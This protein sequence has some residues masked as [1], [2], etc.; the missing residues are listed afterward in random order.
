MLFLL[1]PICFLACFARDN[2]RHT[3]IFPP[4]ILPC[5]KYKVGITQGTNGFSVVL[6]GRFVVPP[7]SPKCAVVYCGLLCTVSCADPL[8]E[9][10][11][12]ISPLLTTNWLHHPRPS[13]AIGISHDRHTNK[14]LPYFLVENYGRLSRTVMIM[15]TVKIGVTKFVNDMQVGQRR[16]RG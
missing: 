7:I 16:R 15:Q 9:A 14:R 1:L 8:L 13:L 4:S 12:P 6:R 2:L 11:S 10:D 3:S 5:T